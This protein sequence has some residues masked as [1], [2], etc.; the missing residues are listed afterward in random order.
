MR[1]APTGADVFSFDARQRELEAIARNAASPP[2]RVPSENGEML[3]LAR[4]I[5]EERARVD[6]ERQLP[7]SSSELIRAIVSIWSPP[8]SMTESRDRDSWLVARLDDLSRSLE[9]GPLRAIEV[10]EL[11]DALDPLERLADPSAFSRADGALARLRVAL[12][13]S[14]A[15]SGK[16]MG[17][18]ALHQ[19]LVVHLGIEDSE[20]ALRTELAQTEARLREEVRSEL[21]TISESAARAN[22]RVAESL[23][24]LEKD[25]PAGTPASK[26]RGFR[27]PPERA[28]LCAALRG[29]AEGT[30][31]ER[32][33]G[34]LA[35]HDAVALAIWAL[36]IQVDD[37]DP[38]QAH[39]R[40]PLLAEVPAERMVRLVRFAA[41]R[42]VACVAVARMAALLEAGGPAER[43]VR[44]TRWLAFGD[45][46]LDIVGREM[47]WA[48]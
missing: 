6:E 24:L 22:L 43:Q 23:M 32:L 12:G 21:E 25:C 7:Q 48:P 33:R 38:E 14:R 8:S 36:A 15:V 20:L 46:P 31:E 18:A 26:I 40:P 37:I 45:A 16:G 11:E 10:T 1:T 17:W 34:L 35:L 4:M 9:K 39:G 47:G 3:L 44:A 5:A 27:P 28:L 42:P 41:V 19:R 30:P 2:P 29:I 13:A